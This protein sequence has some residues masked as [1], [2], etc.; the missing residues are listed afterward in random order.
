M[1][2]MSSG[3]RL[4]HTIHNIPSLSYHHFMLPRNVINGTTI[5]VMPPYSTHAGNINNMLLPAPI[6]ITATIGLSPPIIALMASFYT[7]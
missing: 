7:L 4:S 2:A 5:I 3:W 6:G 1:V